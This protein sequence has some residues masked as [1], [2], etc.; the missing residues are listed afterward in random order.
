[1]PEYA[2]TAGM[3]TRIADIL[4]ANGG[5]WGGEIID[6][7]RGNSLDSI[8]AARIE[9]GKE[10]LRAIS[11]NS[12][13]G[14]YAGLVELMPV[15]HNGKLEYD[16]ELGIPRIVPF[17][18][19]PPIEGF[20]ADPDEIDSYRNDTDELRLYSEVLHDQPDALGQRS[21]V[22]AKYS[23]VNGV[24]K[25]TGYSAEIPMIQLTD[26]MADTKIPANFAPTVIKLTPAK[27]VKEGD[28]LASI[29]G[30][31]LQEGKNDL[32]EIEGGAREVKPL[33]N[34]SIAQKTVI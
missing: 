27:L 28:N 19:A 30:A 31:Y 16:G 8:T 25:F 15:E 33:P 12:Q 24:F 13:S 21:A 18:G 34:I 17:A 22:A 29:A 7:R 32:V 23:I 6:A 3:D 5:V 20:P 2:D 1:M 14:Y 4:N 11:R 9:S 26:E 10:V